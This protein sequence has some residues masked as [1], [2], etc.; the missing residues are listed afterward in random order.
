MKQWNTRAKHY[1]DRADHTHVVLRIV[2]G[3]AIKKYIYT[4]IHTHTYIHTYIR[5]YKHVNNKKEEERK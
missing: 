4:Y 3:H 2:M 1:T 5:T